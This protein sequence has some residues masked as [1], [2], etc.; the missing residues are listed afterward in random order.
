VNGWLDLQGGSSAALELAARAGRNRAELRLSRFDLA[1]PAPLD[2]AHGPEG[3]LTASLAD[4]RA[5][6]EP[7][8]LAWPLAAL[9]LDAD[10]RRDHAE[11]AGSVALE[12]GRIELERGELRLPPG[13]GE[14][15]VALAGQ[16]DFDDLAPLGASLGQPLAGRWKGALDVTG[17]L[18][19]PVGR[20]VGRGEA[21]SVRG[22]ALDTVDVDVQTDGRS[23]RIERCELS[24]PELEAVLRGGLELEP[25]ELVDMAMNLSADRGPLSEL[26]PFPCEHAFLHA[27]LAGPLT[28]PHGAFEA[29]ASGLELVGFRI[30]D[31]EARGRLAG[32]VLEVAELRLLL[33]SAGDAEPEENVVEAAGTL[34]RAADG[35]TALLE[36]VALVWQGVRVQLER[37]AR[38]D[39]APGRLSVDGLELASSSLGVAGRATIALRHEE[40]TTRGRLD[41]EDYHAGAL[42][43]PFLPP[44]WRAGRLRGALAGELGETT[45]ALG[46]DLA[47]EGWRL[48]PDWPELGAQLRGRLE[49]RSLTLERFELGYAAEEGARVAGSLRVP[50]DPRRGPELAAGPVELGLVLETGDMVRSLRR[51]GLELGLA[52]TGPCRAQAELAGEWRTLAGTLGVTAE[53]VTLGTEAGA[54]ACD[55]AA[56]LVVGETVRVSS[57]VFSAPSGTITLSGEIGTPLDLPRWLADRLALLEAPLALEAK[58]DLADV[59]WIAGLSAD[60]RRISGQVAGRVEVTGNLLAPELA[61]RLEW[62]EGELRLVAS[63]TPV[64]NLAADVAFEGDLVRVE[65][66]AGEVG[67]AP[68]RVS[69]TLEPF[70][71][72]PRLDLVVT[73]QNLLLARDAHLRLRADADLVVKGT[74]SQLAIRGEL[75]LAEGLYTGEISPL[76]QLVR[77]GRRTQPSRSEPLSLW[78]EGPLADAELDVH[79]VGP[80]TFEY[81]TNLLEAELR[82]DVWLRGTGAFP[83]LEGPVYVDEASL[84]LPS[85]K[86]KLVSGLLTFQREAPLRPEAALT[87]AMRVQRHDVRAVATGTLDE[88]EIVLTSSPPMAT[89]DLWLLVLTGQVP[90]SR[91]EDRSSQAMEALA[92]FLARDALVRWFSSDADDTESLLERFEIDVGAKSSQSGQPTGRVLF[93]LK[94]EKRRS[95][96]ATYLSAEIDEYD[97]VNYALGIVFR[98]R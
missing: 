97:R 32:S 76:E 51:A 46:L 52:E 18:R 67:G 86:L 91:W 25:L 44:G 88:L 56:E 89:D 57:A 23:A 98:P 37:G 72:F 27:R 60:L 19:H 84:V 77:A 9:E 69:G 36:R 29:S 34:R 80:R 20:F 78:S 66:L 81:R 55:L 17:P 8:G 33:A 39:F 43:A 64:R 93:Y 16:A 22:I 58:L 15:F 96:R 74:P 90:T 2:A 3:R 14:A 24:G 75:A 7:L 61:G 40:G 38:L 45:S 4:A 65:A 50:F 35:F 49:G 73:G 28:E 47:F 42:L 70:G 94:P 6:L 92:V 85:G 10:L 62:R 87:A 11:L 30:E 83:S 26:L 41:F 95:G 68:V 79:V 21:L 12:G 54:R 59:G 63:Q 1:R 13:G 5:L 53:R 48:G 31:A 82:P 71:P